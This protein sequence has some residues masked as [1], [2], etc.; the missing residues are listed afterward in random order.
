MR[1]PLI[2]LLVL[3]FTATFALTGCQ[4]TFYQTMEKFGYHKR[5]ILV[6]RVAKA[7]DSQQE[8]K[9]QFQSALE[10]FQNVFEVEGGELE[11][12][13]DQLQAELNRSEQRAQDVRDRIASVEDVARAL[14]EEWEKELDQYSSVHLRRKSSDQ[15]QTTRKRYEELIAA[16]KRAEARLE[17]VLQPL[18]DQVLFLKH[19]LNARA[20][21]SLKDELA[22]VQTD[23]QALVDDLEKAINEANAFIQKMEQEETTG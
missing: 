9:E 18:R 6:D 10:R 1:T 22:A 13:Y 17:P 19:N 15:L 2:S 5:E 4:K 7:R 8:A 23:V 3:T 21:A 12:T 20:I 11:K 16:M 14:F